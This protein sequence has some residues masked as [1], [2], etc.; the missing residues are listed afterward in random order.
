MK[1]LIA[2]LSIFYSL[3]SFGQN[4]LKEGNYFLLLNNK[5]NISLNSFENNKIKQLKSFPINENSFYATDQKRRVAILDGKK[6]T[7]KLFDIEKSKESNLKIPFDLYP[8]TIFIDDNNLFVGGEMKD[9]M[10]VQYNLKRKKWHKLYIPSEISYYG[11]AIDDFVVNDSMLIAI[12]NILFP[13]FILYYHLNAKKK[14]KL[15]HYI[16]I[17]PNGT[18]EKIRESRITEKYIALFSRTSSRYD[19]ISDHIT[20]YNNLDL[21][22]SFVLSPD[23]KENELQLF[24]DLF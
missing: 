12:D 24:N 23:F 14:L 10:L 7:V 8:E 1:K 5:K 17:K 22:S 9:E 6:N 3:M 21:T 4:G 13:K 16:E 11:K 2:I 20:I 19:G 18:H 15:S